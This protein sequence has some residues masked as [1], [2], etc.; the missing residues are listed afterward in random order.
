MTT[1]EDAVS[2]A[3]AQLS[4]ILEM[5][6]ACENGEEWEGIDP[7]DAI[8]ENAL[9]VQIRSGWH[10][11]GEE[12]R[13]AEYEILLCTGGPA[14]RIVGELDDDAQPETAELQAQGW[15]IPW[16]T[17]P[18]TEDEDEAMLTYALHFWFE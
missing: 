18:T 5:V 16:E 9:S 10:A 17:V 13:G 6:A 1:R 4:T 8:H 2:Q 15:G 11:P 12:H 7:I 14:V 3:R